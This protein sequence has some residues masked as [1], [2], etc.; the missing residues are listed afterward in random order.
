LDLAEAPPRPGS[1]AATPVLQQI[2]PATVTKA[3]PRCW[4][5]AR[6]ERRSTRSRVSRT[7]MFRRAVPGRQGRTRACPAG[8]LAEHTS[9]RP[10]LVLAGCIRATA[11]ARCWPQARRLSRSMASGQLIRE[12][13]SHHPGAEPPAS[14]EHH[15]CRTDSCYEG[16]LAEPSAHSTEL[17]MTAG[18]AHRGQRWQVRDVS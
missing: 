9:G 11:S 7:P 16:S 10:L 4:R 5:P 8:R 18:K 2:R 13:R 1:A 15:P 12:I 6:S 14:S 17:A 3:R